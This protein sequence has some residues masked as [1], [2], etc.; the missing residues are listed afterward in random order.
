[1]SCKQKKNLLRIIISAV[2]LIAAAVTDRLFV[3]KETE[4]L[5]LAIFL[6]P[7]FVIGYDV[8]LKS[9]KN[10]KNLQAFDENL[11]MTIATLGALLIGFFP[12]SE[13]QYL[14]AVFVMLFYKTGELF[15]SIAV[16][17]SRRQV[18]ELLDIRPDVAFIET[19]GELLEVD[20]ETVEVSEIITVRAG[21]KIPLDGVILEGNSDINTVAITGESVP[22]AVFEGDTVLNG[23]VNMSGTLK[24][25]VTKKFS[26]STVS[27]ILELVENSS[28]H[29]SKSENF[30]SKFAKYYT[31][32]VVICAVMLAV[33][34]PVILKG[35]FLS[36]FPL[37]LVRALTFLIISCPCALVIS[38][39]LSF[40]GGIGSA[41]KKGILIK[42]SNYL[43][44]LGKVKTIVFDK[45]GTLTKGDF[46]VTEIVAEDEKEVLKLAAF[47][48]G[49]SNHPI[50]RSIKAA[51]GKKI[52]LN[53]VKNV[54]ELVGQG[55]T[56]TV[57][58]AKVLAGTEKLLE[59]NGISCKP[60]DTV[61]TVVHIA[62]KKTYKG[63]IVI[64]DSIKQ[65]TKTALK[66]L[67][68]SGVKNIVML[69]GD[70]IKTAKSVAETLC[71]DKYF[72]ELLP[73]DKVE[74]LE[75]L[76]NFK[77]NG[78]VAF[79]GDGINDAPVL[80]RADVGIAM[81][82]VG[83]DAAIE[84]ADVVLMDDDLRKIAEAI[85]ISR[86]TMSIV[87]QNIVFALSIK[88]IVLILG[89][90]GFAPLWLAVF[91]DV[92][93]AVVSILNAM[94]TLK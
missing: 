29:K 2:L 36:L 69:T 65:G 24:I 91:A 25:K 35:T 34:P 85:K 86:K 67:K 61:G 49:F 64:S 53:S 74:I 42:G 16:G 19:N 32:A 4:I 26:E 68:K 9:V 23:T 90:I 31:P 47:A 92:G 66:E 46:S 76:L 11:L 60:T 52:D 44:T 5:S 17:K 13:P 63:Y 84:A 15:Q 55:V 83:S 6:V 81:G 39:P 41:S 37:W 80:M 48:E 14:E 77:G 62:V 78:K 93:V 40:F 7:Y 88:A 72:A 10:I 54:T 28:E 20:P 56:A 73:A 33:L 38:V 18:A 8:L 12:S 21:E 94:R 30:I 45:T 79:A 89:A 70:R 87:R 71:V 50:A 43:E 75:S 1:M 57:D 22:R 51:Y 82:G 59:T 3:P 27:K 58:G